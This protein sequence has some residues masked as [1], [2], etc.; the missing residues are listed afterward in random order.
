L[1]AIAANRED[2]TIEIPGKN[3]DKRITRYDTHSRIALKPTAEDDFATYTCE[4]RHEALSADGPM[5]T[6]VQLSVLYP[7]GLPYIE[8]Y[9]EGETIKRGQTVSPLGMFKTNYKKNEKHLPY[10]R[11]EI[12]SFVY[13]VYCNSKG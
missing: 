9:T 5:R 4:A 3:G 12:N 10:L 8:G 13:S 2:Q 11:P 7:P 6:T 1:F